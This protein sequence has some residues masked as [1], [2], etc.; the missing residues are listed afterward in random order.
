MR[1]EERTRK[2]ISRLRTERDELRVR[3]HLAKAE[4]RDEWDKAEAKWE[5]LR[6]EV[7]R[8]DDATDDVLDTITDGTRRLLDE[9]RQAYG[10][11]RDA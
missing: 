11:I 2:I 3:M 6:Q 10:R 9:I 1:T 4:A 7:P 5:Q 8:I